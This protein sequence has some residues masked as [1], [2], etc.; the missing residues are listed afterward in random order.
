MRRSVELCKYLWCI[1]FDVHTCILYHWYILYLWYFF[2]F[3]STKVSCITDTYYLVSTKVSCIT[4]TYYLVSA[5]V[6]CITDT[7]AVLTS[8]HSVRWLPQHQRY[9]ACPFCC[10][11]IHCKCKHFISILKV[12]AWAKKNCKIYRLCWKFWI[13]LN[14]TRVFFFL[15]QQKIDL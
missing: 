5:K 2:C 12:T 10:P 1:L 8:S 6:S 14:R 3:A 7:P 11:A 9:Q 15:T 13:R 4:A